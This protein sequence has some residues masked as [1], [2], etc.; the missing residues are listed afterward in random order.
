[1]LLRMGAPLAL[2][3]PSASVRQGREGHMLL[4][5][6]QPREAVSE[7]LWNHEGACL[8]IRHSPSF[9][10]SAPLLLASPLR[11]KEPQLSG[12]PLASGKSIA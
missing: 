4:A 8:A 2:P 9:R 12:S 3:A 10:G 5:P 11:R 1:M 6:R 7:D